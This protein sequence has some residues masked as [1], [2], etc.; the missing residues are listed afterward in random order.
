MSSLL[1]LVRSCRTA[2]GDLGVL[3]CV[4]IDDADD[5]K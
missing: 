1:A 3:L 4:P 5:E 2:Y